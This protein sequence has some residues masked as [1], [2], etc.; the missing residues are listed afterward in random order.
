[1][2][3]SLNGIIS[4][5]KVIADVFDKCGGRAMIFSGNPCRS[6]PGKFE[7]SNSPTGDEPFKCRNQFFKDIAMQLNKQRTSVDLFLFENIEFQLATIGLVSSFTGGN[8]YHYPVYDSYLHSERL[9]YEIYRNLTRYH[10]ME[11]ACRLRCSPGIDLID[12]YTP[13]G[14]NPN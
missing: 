3:I 10:G 9:Y 1:M 6:G 14:R 7:D 11:V 12:Y 8:V 13:A 4:V 2:F 5:L